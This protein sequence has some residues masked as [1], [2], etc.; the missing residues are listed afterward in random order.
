MTLNTKGW[1]RGHNT[2]NTKAKRANYHGIAEM[3][4]RLW[5]EDTPKNLYRLIRSENNIVLAFDCLK[6]NT[7]SRTC[8]VDGLT[9]EDLKK[10][11]IEEIV[12][13]IRRKL[14]D[15]RPDDVKRVYIPKDNGKKRPLGIPTIWDRLIQQ[16]IKQVIE[17]IC[18]K[19]FAKTSFGFRPK[20]TQEQAIALLF[21]Q[22]NLGKHYYV[23][24]VDIKGFFDNVNH[25]VLMKQLWSI[26]IRDKQVLQIIKKMLKAPIIDING[27]KMIPEKGTP[28]GGILSPLLSNVV[29]NDLDHWVNGQWVENNI[30]LDR[31]KPQFTKDGKE[32]RGN[33]YK[34]F[35]THTRLK[36][37]AII[38]YADDFVI[39]CRSYNES[40]RWANAV[41]NYV[42]RRLKLEVEKDKTK[43]INL[44]KKYSNFLGFKFKLRKKGK[45]FVVQSDIATNKKEKVV[46]SLR[47][48][49]KITYSKNNVNKL[50]SMIRGVHNYFVIAT[51]ISLSMGEIAW[52]LKRVLYNHLKKRGQLRY[53]TDFERK[54]TS[55]GLNLGENNPKV[56]VV[57]GALIKPIGNIKTRN[58]MLCKSDLKPFE[59]E[60]KKLHWKFCI[61]LIEYLNYE[62]AEFNVNRISKYANQQGK[63]WVTKKPVG[64]NFE[65]H[66]IT[67]RYLG[68]NDSYENLIVI[69]EDIHDL[70][71]AQYD[72]KIEK[73]VKELGLTQSQV[74][75]VNLLRSKCKLELI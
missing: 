58:P 74:D 3:Q 57:D 22:I 23:V 67:P 33:R 1:V 31:C 48:Q 19:K 75:K 13:T 53:A 59:V 35:R 5:E 54:H 47:E 27:E 30:E 63:C 25:S 60:E 15:Y 73:L 24:N 6:R 10:L 20:R 50:N 51:N 64:L 34:Y 44:R 21:K 62:S 28:Q 9:I 8:G 11:S 52:R 70:V 66:H 55:V 12:L 71:H 43:I 49:I 29:L 36:E 45:K 14:R 46:K 69:N 7:G 61:E 42:E 18:E 39:T 40:I 4:K 65:C 72:W 68:G 16:C 26:G 2:L 17:P 41:S 32:M 38:R 56:W 37:G